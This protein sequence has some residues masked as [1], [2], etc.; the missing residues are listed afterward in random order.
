MGLAAWLRD[1]LPGRLYLSVAAIA[2]QMAL[3]AALLLPF[4]FSSPAAFAL[5]W[6]LSL[7]LAL[8]VAAREENSSYRT[9][10]R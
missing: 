1:R 10:C 2:F 8:R 5:C 7:A 3:F 4:A 9:A 6:G